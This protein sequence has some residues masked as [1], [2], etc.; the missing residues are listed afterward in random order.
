MN[1]NFYIDFEPFNEDSDYW[2]NISGDSMKPIISQGD[3]VA[4]RKLENWRDFIWRDICYR[5]RILWDY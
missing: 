5:N 4:L 1:P 2:V 3:I